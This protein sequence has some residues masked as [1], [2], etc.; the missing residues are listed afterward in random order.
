MTGQEKT[1]RKLSLS[2]DEINELLKYMYN[3]IEEKKS[4]MSIKFSEEDLNS[5]ADIINTKLKVSL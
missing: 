4:K 1:M 3:M 5:M 2:S